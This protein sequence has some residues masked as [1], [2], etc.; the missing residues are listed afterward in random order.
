MTDGSVD[1]NE[2]FELRSQAAYELRTTLVHG[3]YVDVIR[4][5]AADLG[6]WL[7]TDDAVTTGAASF[8]KFLL[9]Y[10]VGRTGILAIVTSRDPIEPQ[11]SSA[12]LLITRGLLYGG[13]VGVALAASYVCG[14]VLLFRHPIWRKWLSYFAP[15]GRMALT[16]YLGQSVIC[17]VLF[18]GFGLYG[19]V[20]PTG[21]LV[22]TL[23]VITAQAVFS[24]LWLRRFQFGPAEWVWRSLTYRNRQPFLVP[25]LN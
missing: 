15:V 4:A 7:S 8:G 22:V 24:T 9:G 17:V 12:L 18:Y 14:I 21:S 2:G 25:R 23:G 6:A 11:L 5:N 20:G 19:R 1:L 10:W 16:N 3:F 13:L